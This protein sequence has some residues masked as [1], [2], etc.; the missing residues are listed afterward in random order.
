MKKRRILLLS[1][2]LLVVVFSISAVR[3]RSQSSG[4]NSDLYRKINTLNEIIN[5]VNENYVDPVEWDGVMEGAFE[6]L[7][8]RL[9]PHS[10]YIP[11]ERFESIQ[12]QFVGKFEGIG[13]EFDIIDDWITV[14]APVPGTPSER[15][16][17]RA[18]D[19]IVEIDGNS[20]YKF[21]QEQVFET[22]R[23]PKGTAVNIKVRRTG[24]EKPLSFTIIRDEIPI[25]SVL[26]SIM[27]DENTGYILIN[28][29]SS[30]T[31]EEVEAALQELESE[32][33]SRLII[34][35]RNNSGGYLEQAVE[36][37]D[38]F[39]AVEDTLVFTLGRGTSMDQVHRSHPRGTH[40]DYPVIVLINRGSASA[41]EIVAGALQDLDRGLI[42]G[43]TS[44]GK[45]LVQ[46]QWRLS[47]GSALRVTVGRYYTPSGRLIQ[48]PYGE[49]N[50]KY[51]HD[52]MA[53][54]DDSEV[55]DSL[56]ATLPLYHTRSGREVYGGG[57]IIPD[58]IVAWNLK[59]SDQTIRLLNNVDRLLYQYAEL[60]AMEL[61]G[62]YDDPYSFIS[63]FQPGKKERS[64]MAEWMREHGL[65]IQDEAFETDWGFI[66]NRLASEMAGL[67]WD[68]EEQ[69]RVRLE[70]DKQLQVALTMFEL[71]EELLAA[72]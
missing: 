41:S 72:R 36:V 22:L 10:N 60:K 67:M 69:I 8:E 40:P 70:A 9:D 21:T 46:R 51:Y 53:R 29:F 52:L 27:L 20:A 7:L 14:I 12:E 47:D 49:G 68:R 6:G 44:F 23:G 63:D 1:V 15:V 31:S 13:I 55:L 71:A 34:D 19:K 16:G 38:K 35:L 64:R 54:T 26:A 59:L 5:L 28:R 33:M 30:T 65:D 2:A 50:D 48:R 37:A 42:V 39:I 62:R 61:R 24:Q 17:L 32:G 58:E 57:G 56:L 45:G 25:Y 3:L 11:K 43:E 18:G 66:S 4:R